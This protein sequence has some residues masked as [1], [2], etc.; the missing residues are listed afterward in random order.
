V[1]VTLSQAAVSSDQVLTDFQHSFIASL[2]T[3]IISRHTLN[4]LLYYLVKYLADTCQ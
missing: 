2:S 4:M 1:T 3:F